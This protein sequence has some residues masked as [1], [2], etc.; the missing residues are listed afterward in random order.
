MQNGKYRLLVLSLLSHK[1]YTVLFFGV[2]PVT[3]PQR[4]SL[5]VQLGR[6]T[7]RRKGDTGWWGKGWLPPAFA[8][9]PTVEDGP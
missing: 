2:G 1:L 3:N 6:G 4:A 9:I 7:D 8:C 5:H